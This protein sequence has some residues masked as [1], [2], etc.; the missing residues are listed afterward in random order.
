MPFWRVNKRPAHRNADA[1]ND[2]P[3]RTLSNIVD[4]R[5]TI[6]II[7]TLGTIDVLQD[8]HACKLG[9]HDQ[10]TTQKLVQEG[11]G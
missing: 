11:Q 7:E 5:S 1:N 9:R 2:R 10:Y 6:E 4:T 3:S 8:P